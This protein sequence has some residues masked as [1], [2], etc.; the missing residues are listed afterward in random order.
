MANASRARFYEVP[1]TF[2]LPPPLAA[3]MTQS[4]RATAP[5]VEGL[6]FES[7]PRQ[8]K[9]VKTCSDTFTAKRSGINVSFTGSRR[10]ETDIKE[11]MKCRRS[12]TV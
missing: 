3:A 1:S 6:V 2:S 10:Y 5:Q 4:I 8:T 9:F 7:Q 11:V 12:L